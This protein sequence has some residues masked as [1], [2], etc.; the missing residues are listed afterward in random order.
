MFRSLTSTA[1]PSVAAATG[2]AARGFAAAA[3]ARLDFALSE[4][5]RALDDMSKQFAREVI[6]P[7]AAEH[8]QTGEYPWEVIKQAHALGLMNP[9]IPE[10][11]GGLG[12]GGVESCI[13]AE[14]LAYGCS[15][16]GTAIEGPALAEAPIIV[17]ASDEQKKK[18]LGRM[19]E[20][21]LIAS[22]A[23]T[24][25]GAGSDVAGAKTTAVKKGDDWVINGSKMWIT[26][27]GHANWIFVLARTDANARTGAAFTGFIV[28][29]D[30]PGVNVGRKEV[31]VG[32]RASDTRGITFEDVVVPDANRVGAE[33]YGFKLAMAAFDITRPE[34]ASGAVGLADRAK[35]EALAYSLERKTFGTE[36][37]NHQDVAFRIADL[38]TGVQLGRLMARRA[39]W[40]LDQGRPS[41]YYA[42]MAKRHA[43]DHAM[44]AACEACYIF[45][46]N[47]FNTEYPVEK[48]M[49]DAR[50]YSIYEGTSGIQRLN[51]SRLMRRA[52]EAGANP[53]GPDA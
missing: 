34:V 15:G 45:G 24:E 30:T 36:I 25:P 7:V 32:Q 5:Q 33:G 39:A 29:G 3:A 27:A 51:V 43:G 6:I 41:T 26:G 31:N 48:L 22:F 1:A 42:S 8:D 12:L 20:E 38:E 21:P 2:Q 52:F 49:R 13:I 17:G 4:E 37:F 53:G 16:I 14:N 50:I 40:E 23:V 35:D 47:G 46:G 9:H 10:A 44:H 18:Y 28:D 11:Y 19:T